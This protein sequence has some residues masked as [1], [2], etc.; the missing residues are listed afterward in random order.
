MNAYNIVDEDMANAGLGIYLA[1]SVA[2]HSCVPNAI[3]TFEGTTLSIVMLED[4]P[5]EKVDWTK[6]WN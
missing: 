3:A 4:I 1:A 5:G 2:D 6:V